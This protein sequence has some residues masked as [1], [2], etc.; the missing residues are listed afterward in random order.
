MD[1]SSCVTQILKDFSLKNS[2][3]I[4]TTQS[5]EITEEHF[6]TIFS[7]TDLTSLSATDN[8]NSIKSLTDI[9]HFTLKKNLP[10]AALCVT[11]TCIKSALNSL[12]DTSI[13]VASVA[14]FPLATSPLAAVKEEVRFLLSEGAQEVDL[15]FPLSSYLAGTS[16]STPID[17]VSEVKSIC[18][19]HSAYLKTIIQSDEIEKIYQND[20]KQAIQSIG[21]LSYMS[22]K[23]G[24]DMVKTSTGKGAGGA[25]LLAAEVISTIAL[26]F[27]KETTYQ[28]EH[29]HFPGVKY[30]GGISNANSALNFLELQKRV[31]DNIEITP[32]IFRFGASSLVNSL[33]RELDYT[34]IKSAEESRGAY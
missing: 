24:S 1:V 20:Q 7:L 9:A 15:V 17:F 27:A 23:A 5:G 2:K 31:W 6:R 26:Y 18:R 8:K 32:K 29:N 12:K 25:S 30:S 22:Y 14:N 16:H 11:G 19:D 28:E 21:E 13:K 3:S 4:N 34:D 33:L 10:L